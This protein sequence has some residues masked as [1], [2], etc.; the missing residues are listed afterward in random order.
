[1]D[2]DRDANRHLAFGGG[3]HLCIGAHLARLEVRVAL[4]EFHRRIPDYRIADGAE[5]HF[6]G[7]IRQADHVPLVWP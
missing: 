4:E 2:Y 3:H 6:S 5:I 7:G 1:V